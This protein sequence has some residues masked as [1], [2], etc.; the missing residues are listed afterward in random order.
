MSKNVLDVGNCGAD[1]GAL[2]RL[3]TSR[4]DVEISR[5]HGM[6]DALEAMRSKSFDLVLINRVMDRDGSEGIDI[7][8]TAKNDETLAA[9]PVMMITNYPQHQQ[10]AIDAGAAPGFGKQDLKDPE[11]LKTLEE[12]LG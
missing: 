10:S 11:T 1:H 9:T 3:L 4:F 5:A 12:F 7:I 8:R 2:T 6:H